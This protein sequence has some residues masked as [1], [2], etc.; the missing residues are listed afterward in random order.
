M[1]CRKIRKLI[2]ES[3]HPDVLP[4]EVVAHT[5]LCDEC[6]EFAHQRTRLRQLLSA[7]A[8]V[9]A[10]PNFDAVLRAKLAERAARRRPTWLA[11]PARLAIAT[12]A[13]I[14]ATLTA[15]YIRA[16]RS[17]VIQATRESNVT[18]SPQITEMAVQA[19]ASKHNLRPQRLRL[20]E[21]TYSRPVLARH[22]AT[23]RSNEQASDAAEAFDLD[24]QPA[25]LLLMRAGGAERE[26]IVPVISVG[27]EPIFQYTNVGKK[28]VRN[29]RASF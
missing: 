1:S 24:M 9:T 20:G 27:A 21:K 17:A 26:L 8:R 14:I 19:Q 6:R 28:T 5:E 10:P 25:A 12:A 23:I 11:S 13:L 18:S 3:D 15:L 16:D 29:V 4:R 7:S 2:D 22:K